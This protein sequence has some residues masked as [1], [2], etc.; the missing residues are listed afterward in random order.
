MN[1]KLDCDFY[2][3]KDDNFKVNDQKLISYIKQYYNVVVDDLK[4]CAEDLKNEIYDNDYYL[5]VG[6]GGKNFYKQ[7]NLVHPIKNKKFMCWHRTWKGEIEDGIAT[8]IDEIDFPEKKV[9]LIED[10]IASG[11]TILEIIEKLA[12]KGVIVK[13]VITAIISGNSKLLENSPIDIKYARI[14]G[15]KNSLNPFWFPAIYSY[16]HIFFG[17]NE[18]PS[19]YEIMDEKY[20]KNEHKIKKIIE[21]ARN[22]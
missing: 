19:I 12:Q 14:I 20:F 5:C 11:T 9:V 10:V 16:R 7:L 1:K 3:F 17:D 8:D 15:S 4:Y 13:K 21:E 22:E 2:I 6:E 18:M